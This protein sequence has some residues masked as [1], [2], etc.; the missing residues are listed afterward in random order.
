ME[1]RR[2]SQDRRNLGSRKRVLEAKI[3]QETVGS[4]QDVDQELKLVAELGLFE[5]NV[6]GFDSVVGNH[7]NELGTG[8][9]VLETPPQPHSLCFDSRVFVA[10]STVFRTLMIEADASH[11]DHEPCRELAARIRRVRTQPA[12]PVSAEAVE[13]ECV[14]VHRFVPAA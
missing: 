11:D 5:C 10:S 8:I 4:W 13:H 14:G 6:G 1:L 2:I 3:E 7:V 12:K 9:Q